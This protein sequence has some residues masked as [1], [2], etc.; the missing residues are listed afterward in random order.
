M[1]PRFFLLIALMAF[2]VV[3]AGCASSGNTGARQSQ[4]RANLG[5][6]AR[7]TLVNETVQIL[8]S[9]YGYNMLRTVMDT[10]D[11]RFET[12]WKQESALADE[13]DQGYTHARTKITVTARPRNRSTSGSQ[14]LAV[15][16][17]AETQVLPFGNEVW[18]SIEPTDERKDALRQI[19]TYLRRTYQT[20]MR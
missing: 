5:T 6:A 14:N 19:S 8:T 20:A 9:R 10:E 16:F 7:S 2:P 17:V 13:K 18:I 1:R 4:V 12:D 15:N 11:M 3:L